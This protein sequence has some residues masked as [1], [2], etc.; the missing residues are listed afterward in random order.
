MVVKDIEYK[1]AQ[2]G[3]FSAL[4]GYALSF[5][6]IYFF[7]FVMVLFFVYTLVASKGLS[8][9]TLNIV[10]P[11]IIFFLFSAFTLL[12]CKNIELGLTNLFYI[13]CG[14]FAV[15]FAVLS[16]KNDYKL[17]RIYKVLVVI[18]TINFTIGVC[19][20][21]GLFRL[22][23]SP[24]SQYASFFGYKASDMNEFYTFQ[25]DSIL[26][27]PTGFNGNPNTFGFVF[28]LT[29]PFLFFYNNY[30][31][32]LSLFLIVFFNFY[33]QSRGV[34]I[35]TIIFF[36][37]YFFLNFR[38]HFFYFMFFIFV[39][40]LIISFLNFDFSNLR[41]S[42][43]FESIQTGF[44]NILN[45]NVDLYSN[46]TDVR[47]SVYTLGII[48]LLENPILGL[49]LGGIQSI[50]LDMNSPIQSFHFYFLEVL[51]NY[52]FIFYIFFIVFYVKLVFSI[53]RASRRI[54]NP[55]NKKIVL[56]VFYSLVIMPFASIAPSSIVYNLTAWTIIGLALS[57]VY[58]EKEG[59]LN[60][61]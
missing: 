28:I 52:G 60:G 9:R 22:P 42:S 1:I 36:L 58:L 45:K 25:L 33:L 54:S 6:S 39:L 21:L 57:V 35:A 7:H 4:M 27:K 40:F 24:Y 48:N 31:K 29:F 41:I 50:L 18:A 55:L 23:M 20:S 5:Y 16:S 49:G 34:F 46:S 32:Y 2:L 37:V 53:H 56:S 30:F 44:N 13:F 43:S 3:F 14:L 12:W 19:E 11:I 47:A 38:K 10:Y 59:G 17:K 8:V 61:K 51:V 26:S 15:I